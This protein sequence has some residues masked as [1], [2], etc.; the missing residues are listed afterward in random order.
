MNEQDIRE[1]LK[2][3]RV[4]YLIDES[5]WTFNTDELVNMI[6]SH[7]NQRELEGKIEGAERVIG[8]SW[9]DWNGADESFDYVADLR[10]ELKQKQE[11]P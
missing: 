3:I 1:K 6:L 9:G 10:K 11:K 4:G 8:F 2:D 7:G 5:Q